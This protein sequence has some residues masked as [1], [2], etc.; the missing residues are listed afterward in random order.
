[1]PDTPSASFFASSS[2]FFSST[3]RS[4]T[5][6]RD[7]KRE[8]VPDERSGEG[9]GAKAGEERG[10]GVGGEPLVN[11]PLRFELVAGTCKKQTHTHTHNHTRNHTLFLP[12]SCAHA[13]IHAVHTCILGTQPGSCEYLASILGCISLHRVS[14]KQTLHYTHTYMRP[15]HWDRLYFVKSVPVRWTHFITLRLSETDFTVSL[16]QT[17]HYTHTYMHAYIASH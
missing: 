11:S 8:R 17:V 10:M 7:D 5:A 16:K 13:H 14:L 9:G 3:S 2:S 12:L 1:M 15:S 4:T 6:L